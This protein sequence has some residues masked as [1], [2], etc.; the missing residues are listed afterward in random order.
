[1]NDVKDLP[2]NMQDDFERIFGVSVYNFK[3]EV[4]PYITDYFIFN[5]PKFEDFLILKGY[6]PYE[7]LS[8][9]SFILSEYGADADTLIEN[10]INF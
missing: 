3:Q 7:G 6:K 9:K 5:M 1:M 10:I 8:I 4:C 2:I